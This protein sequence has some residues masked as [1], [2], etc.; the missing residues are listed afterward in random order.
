MI[1]GLLCCASE[2]FLVKKTK[3]N[4]K[5]KRKIMENQANSEGTSRGVPDT[6][7]ECQRGS[8]LVVTRK[9]IFLDY[10]INAPGLGGKVF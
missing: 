4:R 2:A 9:K 7:R 5:L 10:R 6:G 3:I 8:N 1:K